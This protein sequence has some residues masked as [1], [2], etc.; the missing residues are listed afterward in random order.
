MSQMCFSSSSVRSGMF[1]A[2]TDANGSSS[3]GAACSDTLRSYGA[4]L[5]A[6]TGAINMT[7]P[8]ELRLCDVAERNSR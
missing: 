3:I 4:L 1:I 6:A 2:P 7:L 5:I 8:T